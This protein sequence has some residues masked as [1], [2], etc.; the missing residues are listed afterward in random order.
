MLVVE[1][2]GGYHDDPMQRELD[3]ERAAHFTG[4]GYAVLRI[5][6]ADVEADIRTVLNHIHLAAARVVKTPATGTPL[7]GPGRG[8]GGEGR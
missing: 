3:R 5:P 1:I 7:P 4:R 8:D 2:D 6:V